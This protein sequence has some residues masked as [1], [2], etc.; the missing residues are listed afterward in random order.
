MK[1]HRYDF[2]SFFF[3][4][5]HIKIVVIYFEA[6]YKY[7]KNQKKEIIFKKKVDFF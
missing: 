6:S 3:I 4:F 2:F 5:D 1:M 7:T